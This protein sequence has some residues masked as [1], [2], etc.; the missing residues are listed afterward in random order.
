MNPSAIPQPQTPTRPLQ[1]PHV[2]SEPWSVCSTLTPLSTF[3]PSNSVNNSPTRFKPSLDNNTMDQDPFVFGKR[4][5][6]R[7]VTPQPLERKPMELQPA[8]EVLKELLTPQKALPPIMKLVSDASPA[9][10]SMVNA[11]PTVGLTTSQPPLERV[12]SEHAG[13]SDQEVWDR[14]FC[15]DQEWPEEELDE[16]MHCLKEEGIVCRASDIPISSLCSGLLRCLDEYLQ[17][18]KYTLPKMLRAFGKQ[19]HTTNSPEELMDRLQSLMRQALRKRDRIGN[20]DTVGDAVKLLWRAQKILVLTGAGISVSCGIPDFRSPD[21]IYAKIKASG[22][23]D[24]LEDPQQMFSLREFIHRPSMFYSFIGQLWP[25]NV[26]PSISHE[27]IRLLETKNKLLRNYTQNIDA[28]E[29]AAGVERV[30]HCHG[31]FET[32]KCMDCH[33]QV[34][35]SSI[36]DDVL[37]GKVPQCQPCLI[38]EKELLASRPNTRPRSKPKQKKPAKKATKPWLDDDSDEE[39]SP[40]QKTTGLMKPGITFFGEKLCDSFDDLLYSDREEVDLLLIIGT[41]LKV[42]PVSE[43]LAHIP[44]SIPQ[45]L[46]NKTPVEHA[47]PDIVLLGECDRIIQQLCHDLEWV[48]PSKIDERSQSRR[49]RRSE[50]PYMGDSPKRLGNSHI[51]MYE[52]AKIPMQY[53]RKYDPSFTR[54]RKNKRARVE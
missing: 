47:N 3:D 37:K 32:A 50:E 18:R 52:G 29:S 27:F 5:F 7:D 33:V 51:W 48:L 19:D 14:D 38:K 2:I 28:L 46:I 6:G 21:G 26:Q 40:Q 43:I 24:D 16:L 13:S 49:R 17:E 4:Q 54:E 45:I 42:K 1:G 31:S 15:P 35:G 39:I 30:F 10:H 41:S 11:P 34:S 25:E 36:K 22:Q 44:H 12:A 9:S 53:A 8:G 23:Y 20:Y